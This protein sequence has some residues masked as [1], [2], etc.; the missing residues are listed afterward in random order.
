MARIPGPSDFGQLV[1][2][3]RRTPTAS[4]GQLDAG[5]TQAVQGLARTGTGIATD[6]A[7]A[8]MT[9]EA[10]AAA[11]A[12]REQERLAAEAKREQEKQA[13]RAERVQQLTAHAG[14]Q[15]GLADL[16]DELASGLS[17]GAFK[18]DD[19]RKQWTERSQKVIGEQLANLPP[20][21]APLINA[22]MLGL[23]GRLSNSLEDKIRANDQ[24]E[25]DAGLMVYKEQMQ[26]FAGTDMATAVKQWENVARTS[27]AQ[28]G[29][30]PDKIEKEVQS[31]KEGVAYTKAYSVLSGAR[32]MKGLQQ[33]E[34]LL[35]QL[36][37][38][39]P[40]RR[41]T[42]ENTIVTRRMALNQE[43]EMEANRRAR[44]AEASFR[45]AEATAQSVQMMSDKGTMLDPTFI[46]KAVRDTAGTPFQAAIVAM[47]KQANENGGIAA[48]PIAT[49]QAALDAINAQIAR[50]GRSPALDKRK[51][52]IE[53]VVS[54]SRADV[55]KLGGLR[56]GLERG[57]IDQIAPLD[58]RSIDGLTKGIA[59]RVQQADTVGR[60]W[61]GG[62]V[63]PLLPEEADALAGT[64]GNLAPAARS[65]A[66]AAL[67]RAV[68]PKQMAAIAKQI[69]GKDRA[70]ALSMALGSAGT[71]S[72]RFTSE[73][74]L[75]GAQA[76]KDKGV[77]LDSS[78]VTG[79]RARAAEY[80]GDALQGKAREDVLDTAGL[81][82]AGMEAE[83]SGDINRAVRM[84]V[85][86]DVIE[87]N[88]RKLPI[89]AGVDPDKFEAAVQS[90]ARKA[91]G[92]GKVYLGGKPMEAAA[93]V[94]ALPGAELEPVGA[95]R[96][97]VRSGAGLVTTDGKKPLILGV[98]DVAP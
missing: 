86:G 62:S 30:A 70:L 60:G 27:G 25:A 12:K 84:A 46:E 83:G 92:T 28:A 74:V 52:Q 89:P 37:D 24:K 21:M 82:F 32:D 31:F 53:K 73:L 96:Y 15:T 17:T 35:G 78:A 26:R 16:H 48:Q 66:I 29:W 93:F 4:A 34:A 22:E 5:L 75:K 56:A 45:K 23:S 9:A 98:G 95:G 36:P 41:A 1:P 68:P 47:A 80:L 61:A 81:I 59:A 43:A 14:I 39:D 54:G 77:K 94:Q 51:E 79:V 3:A 85:G 58:V 91:V 40:Q 2:E 6:M 10:R 19:A 50:E 76:I 87:R 42:L 38:L 55:E 88:G 49:Q 71:T 11:E 63:S 18:K 69:D 57:V 8:R 13:A 33:A 20:D 7:D 72:G 97:I 64:L 90:S 65:T 44:Q 67:S